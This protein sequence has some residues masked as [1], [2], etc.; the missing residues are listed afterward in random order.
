MQPCSKASDIDSIKQQNADQYTRITRLEEAVSAIK[1]DLIGVSGNNGLR[2]EFRTFQ[3]ISREQMS[4]I[5]D[6]LE[7]MDE[8]REGAKRWNWEQAGVFVGIG[9][10]FLSVLVAKGV[11]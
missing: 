10:A 8:K 7:E 2:G 3:K 11:I 6:K 9:V 5:A 1:T 4:K